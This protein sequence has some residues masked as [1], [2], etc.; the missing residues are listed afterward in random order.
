MQ[1]GELS[2]GADVA[3]HHATDGTELV[4]DAVSACDIA[5]FGTKDTPARRWVDEIIGAN[6]DHPRRCTHHRAT[7]APNQ[8]VALGPRHFRSRGVAAAAGVQA[9]I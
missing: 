1:R 3:G 5:A 4:R 8:S 6:C 2:Y 7:S 9:L